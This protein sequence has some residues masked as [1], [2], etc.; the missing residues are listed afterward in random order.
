MIYLKSE[1]GYC[2][3]VKCKI[4]GTVTNEKEGI[5]HFCPNCGYKPISAKERNEYLKYIN[6]KLNDSLKIK[7]GDD[8]I[9]N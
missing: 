6:S 3:E 8:G 4:C 7:I 1:E 2:M 5:V 9:E